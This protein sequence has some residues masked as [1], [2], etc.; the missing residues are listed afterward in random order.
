MVERERLIA[1]VRAVQNGEDG[2]A[3]TLYENFYGDI[4]YF[5]N[6]TVNDP[7]LA[8]DLTQDTF[9]EILETIGKLQEPAAF[10]TWSRQIAYH[11][12]TGH[13]R[14]R[15]ELLAD[16]DEDGYSVFDTMEEERT[17][18]IP[19]AALDQED[20]KRTIHSM[21]A[22]LPEEQ[23][24]ALMMRYFDELSVGQ[25]AQIQGVSEGTV[26]SRLNYG[27]KSI[28]KS[29]EDY[30]KKNGI[31]L[32]CVGVLPLLL[33]LFRQNKLAAGV[34]LTAQGVSG[35]AAGV[36]AD[37]AVEVITD[38]AVEAAADTAADAAAE[39]AA[40]GLGKLAVKAGKSAARSLGLKIAAGAAAA[41]VVGGG[42]AVVANLPEEKPM[43]WVGYGQVFSYPDR[44]FDL[45]VEKMDGDTVTGHLLVSYLY[46]TH[47]ESDF[48][49]EATESED[50][51]IFYDIIFEEDYV[52]GILENHFNET[53]LVYDEEK[54]TFL[55]DDYY[56][57]KLKRVE[58]PELLLE[59]G[60]WSGLGEDSLYVRSDGHL[61][62][63][64]AEDITESSIRGSLTVSFEGTVDQQ[65]NFTGRGFYR[66]GKYIY[67]LLLDTPR[68][69]D[70]F[71]ID[72]SVDRLWLVYD[73]NADTMEITGVGMYE[74][75]MRR[76]K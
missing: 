56:D 20:L 36:A 66:N 76:E 35:V 10:V 13:F 34:S 31:K 53:Q 65:T 43:E 9:M 50:G 38:A 18:F 12:C 60:S 23:R 47:Y 42:V 29:V 2:A 27:R 7:P 46:E 28:K 45:T 25:I 75:F 73:K 26:K 40:S 62:E 19:D 1:M 37:A 21:I 63:L 24:S 5:I 11:R 14:K 32:R 68:D 15:K 57:V 58:E 61:F 49:G 33:W 3:G 22:S 67:E 64:K 6:K 59:K 74:V 54:E 39:T 4:Y 48:A 71:G 30:E 8:E 52:E 72:G 55:F 41:A 70:V 44:R 51:Q 69:Y 17:E 16:E